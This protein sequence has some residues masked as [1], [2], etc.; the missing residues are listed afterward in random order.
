MAKYSYESGNCGTYLIRCDGV[1]FTGT[2]DEGRAKL[3]VD[4]LNAYT[5]PMEPVPCAC[6]NVARVTFRNTVAFGYEHRIHCLCGCSG[7][8]APTYEKAI[9]SWNQVMANAAKRL[10]RKEGE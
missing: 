7:P 9:E 3:I 8:Y 5:P 1:P 6:G 10:E 2:L 4:A